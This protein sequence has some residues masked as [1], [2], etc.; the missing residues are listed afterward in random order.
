LC[1]NLGGV[2]VADVRKLR[3]AVSLQLI[4]NCLAPGAKPGELLARQRQLGLQVGNVHAWVPSA[5]SLRFSAIL[6]KYLFF[7]SLQLFV[8]S[9]FFKNH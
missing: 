2:L 8:F 1:R 4:G 3:G 7:K 9:F 5:S 6:F